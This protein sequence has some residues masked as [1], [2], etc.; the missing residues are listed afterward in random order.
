MTKV[1]LADQK[2][3]SGFN[4]AQSVACV[5]A[6]EVGMD[7]AVLYKVCEGFGAG[8]G[9][10]KGQCGALSGAVVLAGVVNSDGDIE[11]PA[12]TKAA[13]T[14]LSAAML[15]IF[16]EKAGALICKEIKGIDSGK[17]ITSCADCITIAVEAVQEVLG[18]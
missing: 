3:R 7:E 18:L 1:E 10:M 8:L 6:E 13:T 9:C 2:H 12:Q 16:E 11:H 5:F 17:P 4:C 14:K 15:K